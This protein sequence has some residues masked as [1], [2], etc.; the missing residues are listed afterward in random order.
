MA[1]LRG[2]GETVGWVVGLGGG[3]YIYQQQ[4]D[5]VGEG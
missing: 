5:T 2:F 3:W 4:V 1:S